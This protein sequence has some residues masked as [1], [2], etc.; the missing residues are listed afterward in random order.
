MAAKADRKARLLALAEQVK[1]PEPQTP[2]EVA[3]AVVSRKLTLDRFKAMFRTYL[4]AAAYVRDELLVDISHLDQL[5]T[6][7]NWRAIYDAAVRVEAERFIDPAQLEPP[8]R[9]RKTRLQSM[10]ERE[11][12]RELSRMI[13]ED[14]QLVSNGG[15]SKFNSY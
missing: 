13:T 15:P 1:Q 11:W 9:P 7:D 10:H 4:Q 12:E 3:L 14:T 8:D 6:D 2:E 5:G